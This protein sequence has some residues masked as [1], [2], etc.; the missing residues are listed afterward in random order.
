MSTNDVKILHSEEKPTIET[1]YK[2]LKDM[3]QEMIVLRTDVDKL[4]ENNR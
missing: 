4:I 3:Q 2:L 1:V